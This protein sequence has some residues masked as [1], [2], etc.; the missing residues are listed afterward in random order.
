[1]ADNKN[2]ELN[3]EMMANAAGGNALVDAVNLL[4]E[5]KYRTEDGIITSAREHD[6]WWNVSTDQHPQGIAAYYF[7]YGKLLEPGTRVRCALVGMG[8]W[9]I[10]AFL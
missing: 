1:M 5:G 7:A 4:S 10:V 2:V 8:R 6:G 3:E 9:E